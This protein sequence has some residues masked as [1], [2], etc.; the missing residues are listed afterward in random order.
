MFHCDEHDHDEVRSYSVIS[1]LYQNCKHSYNLTCVILLHSILVAIGIEAFNRFT[2]E[3]KE[4][5]STDENDEDADSSNGEEMDE[6]GCCMRIKVSC[7]GQPTC[8]LQ[9]FWAKKYY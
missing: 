3:A 5:N 2:E 7:S 8:V 4:L 6:E 9:Y 1:W